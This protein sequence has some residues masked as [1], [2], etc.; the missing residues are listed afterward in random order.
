MLRPTRVSLR[1]GDQLGEAHDL[2]G[3]DWR[4]WIKHALIPAPS[5]GLIGEASE[6]LPAAPPIPSEN[7]PSS[8]RAFARQRHQARGNLTPPVNCL[9]PPTAG[10]HGRMTT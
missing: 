6:R 7:D 1:T 5:G 9:E 8:G 3:F 4:R 10:E 2:D